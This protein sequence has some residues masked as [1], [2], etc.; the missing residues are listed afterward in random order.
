MFTRLPVVFL[1]VLISL[2][3]LSAAAADPVLDPAALVADY[4]ASQSKTPA[5]LPKAAV[6]TDDSLTNALPDYLVCSILVRQFPVARMPQHPLENHNLFFISIKDKSLTHVTVIAD[7]KTFA[8]A[9]FAAAKDEASQKSATRAWLKL[10]EQ[11][12]NDGMYQFTIADENLKISDVPGDASAKQCVGKSTVAAGGGNNGE[13]TATLTFDKDGKLTAVEDSA[14][15]K[16]GMRPICQATKLLDADPIVRKMAEQDI[17]IM[18]SGCF[19]YLAERRAV[20]APELQKAIDAMIV[21][22]KER[23]R[24]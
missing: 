15:L 24:D 17:L 3:C 19:D 10:S 4:L 14:K 9:H 23:E 1:C 8:L 5:A 12:H 13:I 2:L 6:I 11:L 16:P 18:G 20:A 7:L 21:R 22:I